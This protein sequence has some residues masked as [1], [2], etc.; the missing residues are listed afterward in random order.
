MRLNL[1][2]ALFQYSDILFLDEPTN[3]LDIEAIIWLEDYL[4]RYSKTLLLIS[5]DRDFLNNICDSIIH[6]EDKNPYH[7]KTISTL[8]HE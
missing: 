3:H 4:K 6:F 8:L 7:N 5:H 2:G 1:A